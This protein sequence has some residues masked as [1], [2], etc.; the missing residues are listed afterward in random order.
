MK[1]NNDFKN[2]SP[3]MW[4]IDFFMNVPRKFNWGRIFSKNYDD[5]C[6]FLMKDEY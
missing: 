4:S 5:K 2:R 3:H 1:Q 6:I